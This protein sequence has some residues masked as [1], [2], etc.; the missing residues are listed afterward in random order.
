G[1]HPLHLYHGYLGAQ[2]LR[3]RST[4]CCF[5]PAFDAGYPKTPVFDSGS[6][7]A[8]LFLTFAGGAFNPTAY[9]IGVAI[10]CLIVPLFLFVGTRGVGLGPGAACVAT[11]AGQ[12]AWWGAVGR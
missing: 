7:P 1:R 11:A 3:E 5:D 6:R 8:E 9:K 12:L 2:A 10:C 4:L